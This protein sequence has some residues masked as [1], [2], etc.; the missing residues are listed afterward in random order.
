MKD[1]GA[2]IWDN[3][4]FVALLS[5]PIWVARATWPSMTQ[6]KEDAMRKVGYLLIP[7]VVALCLIVVNTNVH[8]SAVSD[9]TTY[10]DWAGMEVTGGTPIWT[11]FYSAA[12]TYAE[13]NF[14]ANPEHS[15]RVW[16][17]SDVWQTNS[18]INA[19][20]SGYT[21]PGGVGVGGHA[22][23]DGIVTT[24]A[25]ASASAHHNDYF[26]VHADTDLTF[27]LHYSIV[28]DISIGSPDEG[29]YAS[30]VV[31]LNLW[32]VGADMDEDRFEVSLREPGRYESPATGTLTVSGHFL[33][34]KGYT[35]EAFTQ[36]GCSAYAPQ[37][38]TVPEPATLL[39]LGLGLVGV[40]GIRR[41]C[42]Q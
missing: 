37:R 8:A 17:G 3:R 40:A 7:Y 19:N 20:S 5:G 10:I 4:V 42:R 38:S 14:G 6:E 18:V 13:N 29:G 39:F 30:S 33:A 41:R 24:N 26:T 35:L 36:N 15:I 32:G 23:A 12:F 11:P 22:L 31:W 25:G 1:D 21:T 34:G 16:D 27:I 9:V 28:Q 2:R